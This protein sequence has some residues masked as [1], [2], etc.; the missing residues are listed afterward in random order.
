MGSE[1]RGA[2]RGEER[3]GDDKRREERK[4][5][6]EGGIPRT[7]LEG[8]GLS[9]PYLQSSCSPLFVHGVWMF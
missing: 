1:E 5:N 2:R 4:R 8:S 9:R 7:K 3:R 6:R